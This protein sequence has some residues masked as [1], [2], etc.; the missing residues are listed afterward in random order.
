MLE[1]LKL[2]DAQEMSHLFVRA[3][4]LLAPPWHWLAG[5]HQCALSCFG[6]LVFWVGLSSQHSVQ[7]C[8]YTAEQRA[9]ITQSC[10]CV[11]ICIILKN[12][13]VAAYL[14]WKRKKN[15]W[16]LMVKLL[17]T[18]GHSLD[19]R[20]LGVPPKCGVICCD[21]HLQPIV[22]PL[23]FPVHHCGEAACGIYLPE[24]GLLMLSLKIVNI[25]KHL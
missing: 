14:H 7:H 2:S 16:L 10:V 9:F 21:S 3:S 1:Q 23:F 11:Y 24:L 13:C 4:V 18:C 5:C 17:C 25:P 12:A 6:G 8:V 19:L 15:R 22:V 20:K